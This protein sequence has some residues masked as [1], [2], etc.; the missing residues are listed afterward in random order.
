MK[1]E[2]LYALDKFGD[3]LTRLREGVDSSKDDLDKDGVIQRFEFTF[4]LLWKALKM[5]LE[6]DG[7][8]CR[9][10]RESLQEAFRVGMVGDEDILLNMLDDRNRT[11]HVYSRTESERIFQNIRDAYLPE[12]EKIRQSLAAPADTNGRRVTNL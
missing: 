10:P 6:E 7:V 8:L 9:T 12:M 3:A 4:E 11:S 2:T 5:R 1:E